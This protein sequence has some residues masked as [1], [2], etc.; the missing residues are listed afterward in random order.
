MSLQTLI[1][2]LEDNFPGNNWKNE[3]YDIVL[4]QKLDINDGLIDLIKS[5]KNIPIDEFTD[6]I[7]EYDQLYKLTTQ[8]VTI[9]L[10]IKKYRYSL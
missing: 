7:K 6:K 1:S 5:L 2:T 10:L 9:L 4:S 8:S 3:I